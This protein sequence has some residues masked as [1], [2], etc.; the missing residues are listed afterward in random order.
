MPASRRLDVL[1]GHLLLQS[2][3]ESH[4][5]LG[6]HQTKATKLRIALHCMVRSKPRFCVQA[7]VKNP[8]LHFSDEVA[9]AL[10]ANRAVVALESTIISHGARPRSTMPRATRH[11]N[12][13]C[14]PQGCHTRRTCKLHWR[15]KGLCD[16]TGLCRRR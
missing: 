4:R 9:S 2:G 12:T 6:R 5:G 15:W 14:S 3:D 1:S 7:A 8:N 10:N 11:M 16:V 13:H